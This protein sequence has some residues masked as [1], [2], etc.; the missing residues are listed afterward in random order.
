MIDD[1]RQ[2]HGTGYLI[3]YLLGALGSLSGYA[4][5]TGSGIHCHELMTIWPVMSTIAPSLQSRISGEA[6]KRSPGDLYRFT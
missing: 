4:S 6:V 5:S 3:E 2:R 1:S